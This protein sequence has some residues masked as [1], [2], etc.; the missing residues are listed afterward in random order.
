M[1]DGTKKL[2]E[3]HHKS[4]RQA[5]FSILKGERGGLFSRLIGTGK[6]V[7][8]IGCRDGA[9]TAF[10]AEGNT[11]TGVD[12]D[13]N[14][15]ARARQ[16]LGITTMAVDLH[17]DWSEL[18]E[19]KF[20]AVVA[21][22][23]LEHLFHPDEIARKVSV[24][25]QPGGVFVGSVPNAFSLINRLRYLKG[26]IRHTPLSDPTHINQF[27]A[28]RLYAMLSQ[29]FAEVEIIGLGRT[30]FLARICPSWFAF[31]LGFVCKK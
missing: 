28:E 13:E 10:F 8:D 7:L 24:R 5:G 17:G 3:E 30:G 18:G 12:I 4:A 26:S 25:L 16:N 15:L 20:D 31:D 21:G 29:S 19:R 23:V 11:V 6:T 14:A 22:E 2:Y 27:S 9:L 1:T